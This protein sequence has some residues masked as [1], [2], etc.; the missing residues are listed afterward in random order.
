[1]AALTG[2]VGDGPEEALATYVAEHARPGDL[3]DTIRVIDVFCYERSW[4]MNVG[5]E[6]GE[7]LDAAV[8]RARPRRVLELGTYCGYS[9][10]RIVRA[11]PAGGRL[12]SVEL[13]AANAAVARR[14]LDHAGVG[15]RVT[16]VVGS[17]GDGGATARALRA[18]HGLTAGSV[19]LV[20]VDHDK[21]AY[22]P[23]LQHILDEGW[24]HPGA[25]VVGDN[26]GYP[27]APEFRAYLREQE[28]QT[29]RTVE[30]DT[31]LEYQSVVKDIVTESEY[32]GCP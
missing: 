24:L 28:G 20:F 22:L 15:D 4:L 13:S 2:Q 25:L 26:L 5:D 21:A 29:F 18:E 3:D 14:N 12:V 27:G 31:H 30:H 10:L 8:R 19:D 11:M 17:L 16:V 9:A 23:D 1:M 7:I 6:K 32:L